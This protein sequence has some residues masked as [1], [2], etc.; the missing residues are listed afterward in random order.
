MPDG[1]YRVLASKILSGKPK[2]PFPQV[3]FRADDPN[4]LI[5]HEHRRELRGLRVISSWVNHWDMKEDQSLDMYVEEGGRKFLRHYL[6]DFGSDLGAGQVPTEYFRGREHGFDTKSMAKEIVTLGGYTSADE[7]HGTII[8]PEVGMFTPNDFDP[9]GWKPTYPTVMFDNMTDQDAF[10]ATR[11]ICRSARANF[12]ASWKRPSYTDPT[13]TEYVL[14]ALLERRRIIAKHWLAKVDGLSNFSVRP[15][16]EGVA[17]MFRDL[18]IDNKL[19]RAEGTS[20]TYEIK[21]RHYRSAMKTVH[22]T[23]IVLD[24]DV[25]GAAM[26]RGGGETPIELTI[27]TKRGGTASQPVKNLPERD[28]T[29]GAVEIMRISRG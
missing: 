11:I 27:W 7:K 25:L 22:Q 14:E 29:G 12:A 1:R 13:D 4:D 26:E 20:Y 8:S 6:L 17:L 18:M 23:A 15:A 28:S 3:G 10:W 24:R 2:G 5:P 9:A 19:A 21:G 16:Q